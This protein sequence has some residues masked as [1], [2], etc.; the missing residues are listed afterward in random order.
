MTTH[1]VCQPGRPG[2]QGESQLGSPGLAFFHTAKSKGDRFS[3]VAST[4]APIR[5]DSKGW[6]ASSP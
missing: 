6:R 2:P 4:R 1:S 5:S 3:S